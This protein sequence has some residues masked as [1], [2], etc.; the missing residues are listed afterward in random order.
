MD[1]DTRSHPSAGALNDHGFPGWMAQ[2]PVDPQH[3]IQ[4]GYEHGR[5]NEMYSGW[6]EGVMN[7]EHL[8][9]DGGDYSMASTYE[10]LQL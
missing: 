7:V 8:E 3:T 1:H 10:D 6:C 4:L 2:V 9:T 5:S